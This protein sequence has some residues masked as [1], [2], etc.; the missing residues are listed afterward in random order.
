MPWGIV[1]YYLHKTY[2]GRELISVLGGMT[3]F[4]HFVDDERVIE[5]TK[6]E[7]IT[8]MIFNLNELDNTDNLE[9]GRPSNILLTYHVTA[10]EDF[11]RFE[12]HIPKYKQLKNGQLV[13]LTLRITD[14]KNNIITD[15]P[16]VTVVLHIRDCSRSFYTGLQPVLSLV[17][18]TLKILPVPAILV[19][20]FAMAGTSDSG[21]ASS[22]QS[23]MSQA[24]PDDIF[25]NIQRVSSITKSIYF[26][27]Y[28][29]S[30]GEFIKNVKDLGNEIELKF[31]RDMVTAIVRRRTG[32]TGNTVKRKKCDGLKEKLASDIYLMFAFGEG[33][34]QS[35]P[36]HI[37]KSDGR[38][39][40]DQSFQTNIDSYFAQKDEL[41]ALR[42]ELMS[43]IEEIKKSLLKAPEESSQKMPEQSS[44]ECSMF[45]D[46]V[47][48][49]SMY[50]ANPVDA[51][52]RSLP[53]NRAKS[54][55]TTPLQPTEPEANSNSIKVIFI[56]DS[57]L[58][59]MNAEKMNVGNIPGIKLTKPGDTLEGSVCRARDY[60]SKH[61]DQSL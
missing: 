41:N 21:E 16:Q 27:F 53:R 14:Q 10:D 6:L 11:T 48:T 31:V 13:S 24:D 3:A 38:S 57:L 12:P 44:H 7:G 36:K 20:L 50:D 55:P 23:Q 30:K 15:G 18:V 8:E 39:T 28:S 45:T 1:H 9:D 47:M 54:S 2:A 60:L 34:I 4:T 58:H 35:L 33:S 32:F 51:M 17:G 46:S 59:R 43:K 40:S 52:S 61:C 5:T 29:L 25:L 22:S 42:V 19:S 56:G 49:K 26:D 37:L